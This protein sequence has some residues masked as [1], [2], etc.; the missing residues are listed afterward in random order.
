MTLINDFMSLI[1]P[2][3]CEACGDNL[4]RHENYLCSYCRLNL[5][6]SQFHLSTENELALTFKGRVPFENAC[7]LYLY[8]KQGRVQKIL[9][10]IK[11]QSQTEL[12]TY[13]GEQYGESLKSGMF[14]NDVDVIVPVPLHR[15]KLKA[16]G[17]NQSQFFAGGLSSSL[18]K[19]MDVTSLV[20]IK[21]TATQTKKKK[22]Q[23]WENVEGI[24]L[25]NEPESFYKKHILLV[26]DVITT[27]ATI[28]AAWTA[29]RQAPEV[30]IS[31]IS[32]AFASQKTI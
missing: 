7:S 10:S 14:L 27:G 28:E 21:D 19:P 18:N 13:L 32:I 6:R 22:Y 11:Y 26:D 30:R 24:F 2:R 23:R 1:Y 9:H 16:R 4:F 15:K 12:A 8:E 5:P 29:I 31:V 25:L 3:H 17:Y 20:R